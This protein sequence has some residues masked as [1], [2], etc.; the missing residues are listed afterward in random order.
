M[1]AL[2]TWSEVRKHFSH[3]IVV[4]FSMIEDDSR[5]DLSKYIELKGNHVV[6]SKFSEI[7]PAKGQNCLRLLQTLKLEERNLLAVF[8]LQSGNIQL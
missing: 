8:L 5:C 2:L 6:L 7:P 1:V 3:E 4:K